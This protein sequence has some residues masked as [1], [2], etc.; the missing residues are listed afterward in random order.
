MASTIKDVAFLAQVATGT[1]SRYLNGYAI[2]EKN[3]LKIQAA[4]KQLGFKINP[5]AKSLKTNRSMTV[6]V[7][8]PSLANIFMMSII[9]SI[10]GY[11]D[12]FAYSVIVCDCHNNVTIERDKLQFVKDKYVDGVVIMP[13]GDDGSHIAAILGEGFPVV[14]IDRLVEG[15]NADAV[16]VDNVNAVYL[17][18]EQLIS[19]E[20][21]R[22]GIIAGPQPIYTARERY[23]GYKRVLADYGIPLEQELVCFGDYTADTGYQL[24]KQLMELNKPPSAVFISNYEMTIG[25]IMC[26][27]QLKKRIPD[28]LSVIGFDHLELSYVIKPNLAVIIQ[29]KEEIGRRAAEILHQRMAGDFTNF[30]VLKRLK[31]EFI[32]G[33]S[34][35]RSIG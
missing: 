19:A 12:Q 3:R 4:I 2:T 33:E 24:M 27:N 34:I 23:E 35:A 15:L 14:M 13:V 21:R 29:P 9:E 7:L 30:P 18:I 5:I 8:V 10:E 6:A 1:V 28:E 16:V 17:A 25:G 31:T 11:L 20:H 32:K 26:L 22:I